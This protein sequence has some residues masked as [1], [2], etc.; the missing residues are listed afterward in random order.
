MFDLFRVLPAV[1]TA[2]ADT[3]ENIAGWKSVQLDPS[4]PGSSQLVQMIDDYVLQ[5][6]RTANISYFEVMT[7]V[8]FLSSGYRRNS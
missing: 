2:I 3:A 8:D 1:A 7:E 4:E 5:W 6:M